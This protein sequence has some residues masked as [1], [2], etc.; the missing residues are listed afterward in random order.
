MS[1]LRRWR[2][3]VPDVITPQRHYRELNYVVRSFVVSIDQLGV[4]YLSD[5]V[6]HEWFHPSSAD[7]IDD[8]VAALHAAK[9]KE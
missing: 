4:L 5:G 7:S 6:N 8:A 9:G 1:R 2:T 3:T